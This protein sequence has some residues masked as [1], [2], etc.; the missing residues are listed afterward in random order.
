MFPILA[1]VAFS[2]RW[3]ARDT[4]TLD[5]LPH[6]YE[7]APGLFSA[8]GFNGRGLA[9]GTALGSVLAHRAGG[10]P[11]GLQPFPTTPA[12]ALPLD[13]FTTLRFH[14]RVLWSRLTAHSR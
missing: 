5:L 1:E 12:S 8:L 6:L 7:P 3:A 11:A 9:M 2:H 10:E 4:V 14:L 13:P